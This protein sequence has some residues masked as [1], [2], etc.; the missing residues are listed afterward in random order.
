MANGNYIRGKLTRPCAL[1]P[2]AYLATKAQHPIQGDYKATLRIIS[3]MAINCR[4]LKFY[5]HGDASWVSHY[6]GSSHTE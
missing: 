6:D 2:T 5:L 4:E 1:L 3:G